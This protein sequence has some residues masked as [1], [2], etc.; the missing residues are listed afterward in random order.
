MVSEGYTV[1]L[2]PM[3]SSA[4][5][6]TT[7]IRTAAHQP[8]NFGRTNIAVGSS[9]SSKEMVRNFSANA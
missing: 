5:C 1:A 3:D 9:S 2:L 8:S 4:I 6:A 7:N